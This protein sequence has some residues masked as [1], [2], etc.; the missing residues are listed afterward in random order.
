MPDSLK[1]LSDNEI[2]AKSRLIIGGGTPVYDGKTF[3]PAFQVE[4]M[5]RLKDS[6]DR[7]NKVSARFSIALIL[8]GIVMI[9]IGILQL[10]KC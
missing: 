1:S 8:T 9:F 4:M 10:I 6:I 5:R 3:D 7:F 2:V